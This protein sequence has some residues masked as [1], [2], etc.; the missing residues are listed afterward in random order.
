MLQKWFLQFVGGN[1]IRKG[2]LLFF[3]LL[4]A[5]L[6]HPV[7]VLFAESVEVRLGHWL[8]WNL[9]GV[10]LGSRLL[11]ALRSPV[12]VQNLLHFHQR[13]SAVRVDFQDIA[14]HLI[15]LRRVLLV[16]RL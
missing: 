16:E 1:L 13:S 7:G 5:G 9:A 8:G 2:E 6:W 10:G 14:Q 15:E 12:T 3:R 4:L 11:H